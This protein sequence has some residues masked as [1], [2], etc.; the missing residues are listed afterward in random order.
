MICENGHQYSASYCKICG[1]KPEKKK[2]KGL[3]KVSKTNT[4][5]L[6]TGERI[7]RLE[8]ESR[9][10]EAKHI[11]TNFADQNGLN[12]CWACGKNNVRLSWSHTISVDRC[13]SD[14]KGEYAYDIDNMQN[15][16]IEK[17]HPE[18]EAKKIEHH[19]NKDAKIEIIKRYKNL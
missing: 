9:I 12:F 17:C 4:I 19:H 7:P 1:T 13:I 5:Q 11:L 18:T 8:F 6:S 3:N 10:K 16:C 15:E 2:P 14:G